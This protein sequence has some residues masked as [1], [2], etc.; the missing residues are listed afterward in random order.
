VRTSSFHTRFHFGKDG[1]P[2]VGPMQAPL[3]EV[4]ILTL[5][6]D[7][8]YDINGI[9]TS[10]SSASEQV[11][12]KSTCCVRRCVFGPYQTKAECM[13][14][15]CGISVIPYHSCPVWRTSRS[16]NPIIRN[17]LLPLGRRWRKYSELW[18]LVLESPELLPKL[19][20]ASESCKPSATTSATLLKRSHT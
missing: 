19:S 8:V 11:M 1:A 4:W 20:T 13:H 9:K 3:A 2:V 16:H 10:F 6:Y 15:G 5:A 17:N 18:L 7:I 12:W 14:E